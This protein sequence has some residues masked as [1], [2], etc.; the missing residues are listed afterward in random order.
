MNKKTEFEKLIF[1]RNSGLM[2]RKLE[3]LNQE[4]KNCKKCLLWKLRKNTVSGK[5]PVNARIMILGQ[6]PGAKEDKIGK[7]FIGRAGKLLDELLK[8]GKIEKEKVFITSVLKCLPQPP[9]NRKPKKEEIEACLPYLKKQIEIINPSK[10]ILLGE[11]IFKVFFPKEK[12][13]DSRGKWV[14]KDG[15][16]YFPTYH[17]A[18][19]L[20]FP[21]IKKILEKDFKKIRRIIS[22]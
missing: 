8:I 12:L 14:K 16:F 20:R 2:L 9:I 3:A 6:S 11:V 5:G 10:I 19:G 17:P 4:I 7:P 13:K 15:K 18:A 22:F 21:K 1:R